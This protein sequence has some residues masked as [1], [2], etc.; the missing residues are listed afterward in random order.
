MNP[1]PIINIPKALSYSIGKMLQ[2]IVLKK[3]TV[4][5]CPEFDRLNTFTKK[6]LDE[7]PS[8]RPNLEETL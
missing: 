6:L 2:Q 1:N 4:S 3:K 8:K 7:D 5:D